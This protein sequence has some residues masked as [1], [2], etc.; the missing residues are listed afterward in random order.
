MG[1]NQFGMQQPEPQAAPH[2][3]GAV[4]VA[5]LP[6]P[7]LP[8]RLKRTNEEIEELKS[9]IAKARAEKAVLKRQI[10]SQD[11]ELRNTTEALLRSKEKL[12]TLEKQ[13]KDTDNSRLVG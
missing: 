11:D 9:L 6:D 4:P 7:K 12:A 8:E 5:A 2:S 1:G 3:H 10:D 13:D